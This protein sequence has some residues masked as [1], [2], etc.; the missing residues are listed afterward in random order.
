MRKKHILYAVAAIAAT[1]GTDAAFAQSAGS[2]S[3]QISN[4]E[5]IPVTVCA[6]PTNTGGLTCDNTAQNF[7][8]L[9]IKTSSG[10]GTSLL[11][12]GSLQSQLVTNTSNTGGNGKQTATGTASVGV[13]VTV[14]NETVADALNQVGCTSNCPDGIAY[15]PAVTFNKRQQTLSSTLG[16]ICSTDPTT[17]ITTCSGNEAIQL[18]LDTTSANSFNFVIPNLTQGTHTV[19]FWI[20]AQADTT[21]SSLLA[22]S[23]AKVAVG[24]GA[25][26]AQVVKVQTPRDAITLGTGNTGTT[27][28]F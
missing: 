12:G 7:L 23:E 15:P 14:D 26:T 13:V 16:Q 19:N 27:W 25:L 1:F 2:F 17:Q 8:T 10:S 6:T 28:S 18:I 20:F 11:V 24:V 5:I 22:G 9:N 3:A 4:A 21:S